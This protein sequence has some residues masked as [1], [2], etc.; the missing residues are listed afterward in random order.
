MRPLL[1]LLLNNKANAF[2]LALALLALVGCASRAGVQYITTTG[3]AQGTSYN[4]TYQS[5]VD[6]S[7]DIEQLLAEFDHSLSFYSDSSLL[8]AINSGESSTT[9]SLFCEVYTLSQDIYALSGGLF[10]PTLGA[11]FQLYKSRDEEL[12]NNSLEEVKQSIG[13]NKTSLRNGGKE[14][15]KENNATQFDFSGIAQGL[16]ADKIAELLTERGVENYMVEIG[17]EIAI[18]GLSPRGE[19]WRIGIDTPEEGNF[20]SGAELSGII[21]LGGTNK[22]HRP[23]YQG[24]ATSGNYRKFINLPTGERITHTINPHTALPITHNLLSAT[25]LAPTAALAD[26]I[27]TAALVGGLEWT[28]NLIDSMHNAGAQEYGYYLIY[29]DS[30]GAMQVLSTL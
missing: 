21:E 26:G 7:Q 14:I 30:T 19:K 6:Y 27:A 16:S 22:H 29:A 4:I 5:E 18:S 11:L 8:W 28:R 25:I 1:T 3:F 9:D 2:F 12:I 23:I 13:L 17:G 15:I 10:D 24:V 20:V